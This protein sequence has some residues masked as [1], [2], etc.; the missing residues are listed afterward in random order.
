MTGAHESERGRVLVADDEAPLRRALSTSLRARGYDVTEAS[1]G[2]QA[3]VAVADR[4]CDLVILDLG[5]GDIEG[6]EVLERIRSFSPVPVIV[7][8]ARHTQ[9]D[10]VAL[11]DAGADDYVT[12]PF[13]TEELLA[14][15]RAT[16]R[17]RPD[18]T[19]DTP[20][21]IEEGDVVIDLPRRLVTVGG[22]RVPLTP[23]ELSML[24]VMVTNPGRL[25]THDFLLRQVWGPGYSQESNYLRTYV[26]QLRK[27][28]GDDAASPRFIATE[29]GIGY[30]WLVEGT[31]E[32]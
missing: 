10:K 1:S 3:V 30:R 18:P 20:A 31:S 12:K 23:T 13:D 27:K 17:R 16:L 15:I 24:E 7:L 5:L 28:L 8:T 29:P 19:T 14:R 11:L 4:A 9:S 2:E 26:G 32:P 25:L 6:L 21:H 22:E